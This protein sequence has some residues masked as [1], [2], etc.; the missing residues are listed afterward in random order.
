MQPLVVLLTNF[1]LDVRGGTQL[2]VRDVALGLLARGHTPVAYST[3]LGEVA[4]ELAAATIPVTDDLRTLG[5]APDLVHGHH[6][7]ELFTAL[8]RFPSAPAVRICHGWLD[9]RPQPFPR[10]LRYLAV[11]DTTRDRCLYEWGVPAERLDVL[12]NFADLERFA[13]RP[14]LPPRPGRAL[15]FSH[16]A[17]EHCWAVRRACE[18]LG[19]SLDAVGRSVGASSASPER[20]LREYDLV[21]AK[22][23]A[24]LEAMACGTA[25][26]LCDRSGIGPMVTAGELARLRRLN[27]GMRT[28]T[29]GL[30]AGALRGEIER[31]D[32]G[33]AAEVSRQIRATAGADAAIESLLACYRD[34]LAEH[35]ATLAD[36]GDELRAAS[37]YLYTLTPRVY[38]TQTAAAARHLFLRSLYESTANLPGIRTVLRTRPVRRLVLAMG[39]WRR[40]LSPGA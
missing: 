23:R 6:N 9:E 26:V 24:A 10:V 28:L 3:R 37:T 35:R 13:P 16:N 2:Y 12:L 17:R 1:D 31:Y 14:P 36:T 40:R 21:F 38:W 34:V 32:P 30:S 8:L 15:V 4:R 39:D 18:D 11:D 27:F 5:A 7:H 29:R 20:I 22:G 33:D 25:V 19:I